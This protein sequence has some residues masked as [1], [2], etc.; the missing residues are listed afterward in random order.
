M[1]RRLKVYGGRVMRGPRQRRAVIAAHNAQQVADAIGNAT[2]YYV[3]GYWCETG[4][5]GDIAAA[6][7]SP[8]VLLVETAE[9]SGI[10]EPDVTQPMK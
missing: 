6:M 5:T 7:A 4:N 3:R 8:G 10:Y 9:H 1:A 2:A